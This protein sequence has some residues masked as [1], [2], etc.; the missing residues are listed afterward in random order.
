MAFMW[1]FFIILTTLS[2]TQAHID[3]EDISSILNGRATKPTKQETYYD[4]FGAVRP[5]SNP[6]DRQKVKRSMQQ[7]AD[8]KMTYEAGLPSIVVVELTQKFVTREAGIA[9]AA[10]FKDLCRRLASRIEH[11]TGTQIYQYHWVQS[12]SGCML[13]ILMDENPDDVVDWLEEQWF[14]SKVDVNSPHDQNER[15]DD[16][17]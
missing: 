14:V 10:D 8:A 6:V 2:P 1:F 16:D 9:D 12:R 11:K 5:R 3:D 17:K 13:Q 4:V 7:G 15:L